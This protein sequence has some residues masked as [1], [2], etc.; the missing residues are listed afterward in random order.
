MNMRAEFFGGVIGLC[1]AMLGAVQASAQCPTSMAVTQVASGCGA[2]V[3]YAVTNTVGFQF[4]QFAL[5]GTPI[6]T[7]QSGTVYL[8]PGT[9]V[10]SVSTNDA[11]NCTMYL[12]EEVT[13]V[14]S[15]NVSFFSDTIACNGT[16]AG[17]G[18]QVSSGSGD[19]SYQWSPTFA[20]NDP[21]AQSPLII[22]TAPQSIIVLVTDN[23]TGCMA[24]PSRS[25]S[26]RRWLPRMV[27]R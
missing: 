3:S 5:D 2:D 22:A 4:I 7:Q 25:P 18:P 21:T 23:Q 14:S 9:Y 17:V 26:T 11:N 10:F 27:S 6:S 20:V 13:V 19:Y 8:E 12:E 15:L 24:L 16:L 1:I